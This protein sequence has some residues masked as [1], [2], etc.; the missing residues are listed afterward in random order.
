MEEVLQ[1]LVEATAAWLRFEVACGRE[2]FLNEASLAYPLMQ[3]A[4]AHRLSP[5]REQAIARPAATGRGRPPAIDYVFLDSKDRPWFF[6]EAKYCR[7]DPKELLSDCDRLLDQDTQHR[8]LLLTGAGDISF[9]AGIGRQR[10][11]FLSV[12]TRA[13]WPVDDGRSSW[14]LWQGLRRQ[15]DAA[16]KKG[17]S[18]AGR[19]ARYQFKTRLEHCVETEHG[20]KFVMAGVWKLGLRPG[21]GRRAETSAQ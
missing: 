3:C 21:A 6:M 15:A 14:K 20:G 13:W 2:R 8:Y 12:E 19:P 17:L 16:D 18:R 4:Q 1:N 10:L 7:F 11:D 9:C 5:R